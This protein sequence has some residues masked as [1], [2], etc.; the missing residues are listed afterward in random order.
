MLVQSRSPVDPG[1]WGTLCKPN[2]H[3]HTTF[4]HTLIPHT[5]HTFHP[6]TVS[7]NGDTESQEVLLEHGADV[8]KADNNGWTPLYIGTHPTSQDHPL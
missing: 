4:P 5:L 1:H 2:L 6:K 8:N 7:K 3:P